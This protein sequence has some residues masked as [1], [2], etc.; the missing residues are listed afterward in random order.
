MIRLTECTR[1]GVKKH[2]LLLRYDQIA[3][4]RSVDVRH[5][6]QH[7]KH[8]QITD[9]RGTKYMVQEAPSYIE[10][11]IST[12]EIGA[13]SKERAMLLEAAQHVA[14]TLYRTLNKRTT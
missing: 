4:V 13:R 3:S 5:D 14:D 10:S 2:R 1:K 6:G 7:D 8:T 11:R 9:V 12:E